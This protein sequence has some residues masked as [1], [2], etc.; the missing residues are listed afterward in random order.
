MSKQTPFHSLCFSLIKTSALCAVLVG[1][2]AVPAQAV[3]R[4][5]QTNN[6]T[7]NSTVK[8]P[9]NVELSADAAEKC[10][11]TVAAINDRSDRLE[12]TKDKQMGRYSTLRKKWAG[13]LAY[14]S[15]W[16]NAE[17]RVFRTDIEQFDTKVKAMRQ[18]YNTQIQAFSPL[19]ISP[20]DC[21]SAKRAELK[22]RIAEARSGHTKLEAMRKDIVKHIR[23]EIQPHSKT[24]V[25]KMH[26]ERRR[27]RATKL[28]PVVVAP[29]EY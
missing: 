11:R 27:D 4:A 13:R 5:T 6:S 14:A 24:M 19:K 28:G 16:A 2:F 25:T 18:E 29:A 26:A 15:Q 8:P 3:D 1:M 21:T 10:K 9:G 20:V 23:T 22:K 7:S 17:G 12:R